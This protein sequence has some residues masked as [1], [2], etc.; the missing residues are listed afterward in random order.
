[1]WACRKGNKGHG[2][3][4]LLFLSLN[5]TKLSQLWI[6][7]QFHTSCFKHCNIITSLSS[8]TKPNVSRYLIFQYISPRVPTA[9]LLKNP[10]LPPA[11]PKCAAIPCDQLKV[12]FQA[13]K[14]YIAD[15]VFIRS[16]I[17]SSMEPELS[18]LTN[19]EEWLGLHGAVLEGRRKYWGDRPPPWALG[20]SVVDDHG[21]E[22]LVEAD[23]C[24]AWRA[25]GECRDRVKVEIMLLKMADP[26]HIDT[27][28]IVFLLA[29]IAC[30]S[31]SSHRRTDFC[32]IL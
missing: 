3:V 1:M 24:T 4:L 9:S 28:L 19:L 5:Y 7:P 30:N 6:A 17:P 16:N 11:Y 26:H 15:R 10:K 25:G 14:L 2:M 23:E 18:S 22:R 21:R 31:L 8:P 27:A 29:H 20:R 12:A 32:E 13:V